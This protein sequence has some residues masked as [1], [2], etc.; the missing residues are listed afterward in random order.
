MIDSEVFAVEFAKRLSALVEDYRAY[1]LPDELAG[2][3]ESETYRVMGYEEFTLD[4]DPLS[5]DLLD[6]AF[7]DYIA[8]KRNEP[9]DGK[10]MANFP[11]PAEYHAENSKSKDL[12]QINVTISDMA[13][14]DP[15]EL[16]KSLIGKHLNDSYLKVQ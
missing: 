3:L 5:E 14:N 13:M 1:L 6:D 4:R 10:L 9:S 8:D 7:K 16:V 12:G 11:G 15:G 2:I